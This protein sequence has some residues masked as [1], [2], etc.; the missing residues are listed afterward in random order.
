MIQAKRQANALH[1]INAILI[2]A[3][4]LAYKG[5][6]AELA[7]VLDVA[8]YLPLLMMDSED[9]TDAFRE[10]LEGLVARRP[11]FSLALER[12]DAVK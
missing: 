6:S 11:E 3:R 7:A 10:Q 1:A 5:E 8:E 12:F 2:V 4:H 9:R